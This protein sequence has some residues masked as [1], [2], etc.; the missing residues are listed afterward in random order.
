MSIPQVMQRFECD[1]TFHSDSNRLLMPQTDFPTKRY[2]QVVF[3]PNPYTMREV[4]IEREEL[5]DENQWIGYEERP[6][7]SDL[8]LLVMGQ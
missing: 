2:R 3:K 6:G 5:P 1:N 8:R 7:M 4:K